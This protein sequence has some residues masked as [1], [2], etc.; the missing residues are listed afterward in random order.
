M[1][2]SGNAIVLLSYCRSVGE[3]K[4][5]SGT[6]CCCAA[7]ASAKWA[8]SP[9]KFRLE[10]LCELG[11]GVVQVVLFVA[12]ASAFGRTSLESLRRA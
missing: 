9:P 2:V 11:G 3:L 6:L 7:V 1:G 12:R 5:E 8:G 10:P 4:C